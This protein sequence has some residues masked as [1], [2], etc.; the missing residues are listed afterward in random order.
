MKF[1]FVCFLEVYA[2][3]IFR[4]SKSNNES[5]TKAICFVP[6]SKIE[7]TDAG[8]SELCRRC[9]TFGVTVNSSLDFIFKILYIQ[10]SLLPDI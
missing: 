6:V 1:T 5:A 10:W 3:V 9:T 2:G 8:C 7:K 4:I